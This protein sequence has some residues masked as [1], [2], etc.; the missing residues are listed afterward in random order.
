MEQDK[1]QLEP[2]IAIME[3]I[4]NQVQI[5]TE[6]VDNNEKLLMDDVIG[7]ITRTYQHQEKQYGLNDLSQK[8]GSKLDPYKD[9]YSELTGGNDA[10]ADLYE[11]I[12]EMKNKVEEWD[13]TKE[14]EFVNKALEQLEN[15][16]QS[17]SKFAKKPEVVETEIEVKVEPEKEVS[18]VDTQMEKIKNMKAKAGNIKF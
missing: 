8:Y 7:G 15:K 13:D 16:L 12:Q 10:I 3:S 4:L 17:L 11:D 1:E 9:F 18:E 14:G 2:L 6:R 5:L